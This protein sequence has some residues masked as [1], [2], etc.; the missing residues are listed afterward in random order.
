[1]PLHTLSIWVVRVDRAAIAKW[2]ATRATRDLSDCWVAGRA[3]LTIAATGE[4]DW[5]PA[6]AHA[7]ISLIT[8][9]SWSMWEAAISAPGTHSSILLS[10]VELALLSTCQGHSGLLRHSISRIQ[11][12]HHDGIVSLVFE[13]GED[14]FSCIAQESGSSCGI[15]VFVTGDDKIVGLCA[16][17]DVPKVRELGFHVRTGCKVGVFNGGLDFQGS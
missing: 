17:V 2:D 11:L 4:T 6:S 10:N 16:L 7:A 15:V 5:R 3:A 9:V 8:T 1:M 14:I 13:I 12:G